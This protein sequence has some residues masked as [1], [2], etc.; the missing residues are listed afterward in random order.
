MSRYNPDAHHRRSIRLKDYD[1]TQNGAYYVT[2]CTHGR[3]C[4][5]G[6]IVDGIMRLN[7]IG[8]SVEEEWLHTSDVRPNVALDAFI[9]MPNHVHGIVVITSPGR[10]VLQYAPTNGG[11]TTF[12]S[13]AQTIGAMVRGFKGATTKRINDLRNTPGIPVW[14]RN[15][16]EHI[17][18]N[19]ADLQ[20]I[21]EYIANN[22]VR[23]AEDQNNPANMP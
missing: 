20:R 22:P 8:R 15:Y 1:Y 5:F 13:P 10:G 23:W 7:N 21:R 3:A 11:P 17:I 4:L 2:I 6:E 14:Q 9:I 16:Y 12:R 19:E 18:R